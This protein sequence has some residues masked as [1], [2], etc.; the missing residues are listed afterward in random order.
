MELALN[1]AGFIVF[2]IVCIVIFFVCSFILSKN[3]NAN[4][5]GM[6]DYQG[7]CER[8]GNLQSDEAERIERIKKLESTD[9]GRIRE[10]KDIIRKVD[11]RNEE[12]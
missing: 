7:G 2:F 4:S 9:E 10:L 1:E 6:A 11:E 5:G 8:I 3:N 12:K